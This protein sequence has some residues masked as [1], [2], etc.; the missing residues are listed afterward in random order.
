VLADH[1][2]RA[3]LATSDASRAKD[4]YA[5]HLGWTPT[6]EYVGGL[7]Y[8]IGGAALSV[9]ETQYA[10]TAK[11][12]VAVWQ[13][14]E[15]APALTALRA[16]GVAFD[17]LEVGGL[18]TVDGILTDPD[19]Y[20]NA[21]FRDA[22]GN[23]FAL[24]SGPGLAG[25]TFGPMLAATDL[26]RARRWY[27]D[28]LGLEPAREY[29]DQALG[30]IT[31]NAPFTMYQT[32]LAGT[33]RNTVGRW[34]IEDPVEFD[35]VVGELKRRGV[36]FEEYDFGEGDRTVDGIFVESDGSRTSWLRDSEGSILCIT[37]R[38]GR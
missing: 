16:R 21:W 26:V 35:A 5:Q 29:G 33:A 22:D 2:L 20:R 10:G 1:P 27:R 17:D 7:V 8:S 25:E 14:P 18:R 28:L 13:V 34:Q 6:Q 37:S 12:T 19:G 32:R 15:V 11:N 31:G 9:Y 38:I 23:V 4:W 30:F 24:A 36:R 3:S